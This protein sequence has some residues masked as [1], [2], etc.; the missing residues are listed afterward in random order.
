MKSI[1]TKSLLIGSFTF[2]CSLT[3]GQVGDPVPE[4]APKSVGPVKPQEPVIYDVV[5]E[6]AE[7]PGGKEALMEYLKKNLKYPESAK[8]NEFEGK[9]Y[10]QFIVSEHGYISNVKIRKG[11]TDCPECDQEAVRVIKAMPK[12]KPGKINGKPVNSTYTLPIAFKL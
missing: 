10:L 5:D 2:I 3:F 6:Q 11:V 12:W 4:P 9:C 1:L 8:E 7:F